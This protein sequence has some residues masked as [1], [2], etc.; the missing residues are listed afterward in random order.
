V[1]AGGH[2]KTATQGL[3]SRSRSRA[4]LPFNPRR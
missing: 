3:Y 4:A 1:A 2:G